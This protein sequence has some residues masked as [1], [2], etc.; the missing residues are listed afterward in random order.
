[1]EEGDAPLGPTVQRLPEAGEHPVP[2]GEAGDVVADRRAPHAGPVGVAAQGHR[3]DGGPS[4]QGVAGPGVELGRRRR[5]RRGR[6]ATGSRP[7]TAGRRPP[8]RAGRSRR[9]GAPATA[10]ARPQAVR[11]STAPDHGGVRPSAR[12]TARGSPVGPGPLPVATRSRARTARRGGRGREV[13]PEHPGRAGPG[14]DDHPVPGQPAGHAVRHP[15]EQGL[16]RAPVE[17]G[18]EELVDVVAVLRACVSHGG[19]RPRPRRPRGGLD[20]LVDDGVGVG[21]AREH[22]LVGAGGQG[23]AP[24]EQRVEEAGVERGRRWCGP[25]RSRAAGSARE[26]QPDEGP[27][28]RD[29]DRRA[30]RSRRRRRR[31]RARRVAVPSSRT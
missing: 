5:G 20:D 12:T 22:D 31:P 24:V 9:P 26:V 15:V 4:G 21:Q 23:H 2:V 3:G 16:H 1:M 29:R 8:P 11:S 30:R 27:L 6:R 28:D 13:P 10:R 25:C 7:R 18:G 19:R 17:D 14:R